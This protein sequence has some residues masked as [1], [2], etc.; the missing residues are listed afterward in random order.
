MPILHEEC[1]SY[2]DKC[3]ELTEWT[4]GAHQATVSLLSSAGQGRE[5]VAREG[6]KDHSSGTIADKTDLTWQN[7]FT[8]QIR[9]G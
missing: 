8:C 4:L 7:Q 6:Q 2:I 1:G 3:G 9:V 5:N